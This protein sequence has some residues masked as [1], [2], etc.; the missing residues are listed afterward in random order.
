MAL[1]S[2]FSTGTTEAEGTPVFTRPDGKSLLAYSQKGDMH[3]LIYTMCY[4]AFHFWQTEFWGKGKK[5]LV[6]KYCT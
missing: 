6:I 4:T 5:G 3:M 1:G 2:S